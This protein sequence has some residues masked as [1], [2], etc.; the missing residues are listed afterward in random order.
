LISLF[1]CLFALSLGA[2]FPDP[3]LTAPNNSYPVSFPMLLPYAILS[4]V[5]PHYPGKPSAE[6]IDILTSIGP[7]GE[8]W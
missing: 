1:I 2:S 5:P 6:A 8:I 3:F 4:A 7:F